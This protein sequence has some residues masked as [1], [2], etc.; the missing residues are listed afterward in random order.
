MATL[1]NGA[2]RLSPNLFLKYMFE[3]HSALPCGDASFGQ[4]GDM[5]ELMSTDR[6]KTVFSLQGRLMTMLTELAV[7]F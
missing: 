4:C 3:P 1:E 7:G 6:L 2:V 5:S